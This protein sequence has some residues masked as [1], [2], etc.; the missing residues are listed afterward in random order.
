MRRALALATVA[1]VLAGCVNTRVM[2]VAPDTLV[3]SGR[4][5]AYGGAGQL[6]DAILIKA[7]QETLAAGYERFVVE[8][9]RDQSRGGVMYQPGQANTTLLGNTATTTYSPGFATTYTIPAG[10]VRIRMFN[11]EA[12]S[13]VYYYDARV[14]LRAAGKL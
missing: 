1:A 8:G 14:I 3:I 10:A 7:S 13:G 11:G 9:V 2:Q 5:N 6:E 12:P 4:G